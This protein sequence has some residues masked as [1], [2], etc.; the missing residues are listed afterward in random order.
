MSLKP[1][2]DERTETSKR[3]SWVLRHGAKRV[4]V[5]ID[6]EGWVR[7][8]DPLA[9]EILQGSGEA[10]ILSVI[11]ESNAQKTRYELKDGPEGGRLIRAISKSRRNPGRERRRREPD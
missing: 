11:Q 7:V 5:E 1:G 2:D 4:N 8:E 3:I 10:K 9:C 6:A